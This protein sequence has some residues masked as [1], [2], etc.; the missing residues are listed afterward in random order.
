VHAVTSGDRRL[1]VA[2]HDRSDHAESFAVSI[3]AGQ[4]RAPRSGTPQA[5]GAIACLSCGAALRPWG[6]ARARRVR[7]LTTTALLRPRRARCSACRATHVLLSGTVLPRRADTT[8][9]IGTALLAG[10]RGAGHRQIAAD[11]CDGRARDIVDRS[12]SGHP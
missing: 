9:V 12:F 1:P 2:G 4:Q 10:A 6:H 7:D 3:I 8:A 11:L 5:A